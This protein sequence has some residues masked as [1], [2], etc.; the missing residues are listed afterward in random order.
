[1]INPI[2]DLG[3]KY[4]TYVKPTCGDTDVKT[5]SF[6]D[7]VNEGLEKISSTTGRV[8]KFISNSVPVSVNDVKIT[9][10]YDEKTGEES[11]QSKDVERTF[12][13]S[14]K[15]IHKQDDT[16]E[17]KPE[18]IHKN[19][20]VVDDNAKEQPTV[21]ISSED[22]KVEATKHTTITHLF[23][24]QIK[25]DK[26]DIRKPVFKRTK[27]IMLADYYFQPDK[28]DTPDTPDTPGDHDDHDTPDTPSD[29]E[30]EVLGVR[31]D[32]PDEGKVLGATRE[33]PE[34]LGVNRHVQT[35]DSG[36][37]AKSGLFASIGAFVLAVWAKLNKKSKKV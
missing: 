13:V 16:I 9:D 37:M 35:S 4:Y 1:M 27:F 15:K 24:K 19:E 14:T 20:N 3:L 2:A 33:K 30:G 6:V 31:R 10:H 12:K 32:K 23:M 36:E 5:Q 11:L 18:S 25:V 8:V 21:T 26:T 22:H 17:V 28:P 29:D 7:V 34:V